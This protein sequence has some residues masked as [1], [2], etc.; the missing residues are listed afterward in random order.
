MPH[1]QRSADAERARDFQSASFTRDLVEA[2]PTLRFQHNATS[3]EIGMQKRG[4]ERPD[5]NQCGR[6]RRRRLDGCIEP[7]IYLAAGGEISIYKQINNLS[8]KEGNLYFTLIKLTKQ[9]VSYKKDELKIILIIKNH[10]IKTRNS[11]L[12]WRIIEHYQFLIFPLVKGTKR[13]AINVHCF[14]CIFLSLEND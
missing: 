11:L 6:L 3:S 8:K 5:C 12:L 14:M 1:A 7:R 13:I 10:Q 2:L 9:I 4:C